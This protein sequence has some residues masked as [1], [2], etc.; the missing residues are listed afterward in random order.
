MKAFSGAVDKLHLL[1]TSLENKQEQQ[2]NAQLAA[3]VDEMKSLR[4]LNDDLKSQWVS[5]LAALPSS[6]SADAARDGSE[7]DKLQQWKQELEEQN[8]SLGKALNPHRLWAKNAGY[9]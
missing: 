6:L 5:K 1:K 8:K 7:I 3:S 2:P 9:M 4:K